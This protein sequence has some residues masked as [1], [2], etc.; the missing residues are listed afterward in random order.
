MSVLGHGL[1]VVL[2]CVIITLEMQIRLLIF[3]I[4]LL[5]L[6]HYYVYYSKRFIDSIYRLRVML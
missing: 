1:P 2:G 6:E 3:N 4:M 5:L